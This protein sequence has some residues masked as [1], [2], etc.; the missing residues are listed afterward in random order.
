MVHRHAE[1]LHGS[2]N[3]KGDPKLIVNHVF[4]KYVVGADED[5]GGL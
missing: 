1:K 2:L 4:V 3:I 5:G